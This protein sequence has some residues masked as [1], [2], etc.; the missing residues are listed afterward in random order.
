MKNRIINILNI[1]STNS[2]LIIKKILYKSL[3]V[4]GILILVLLMKMLDSRPTNRLLNSINN[5][6]NYDFNLVDDSKKI[7]NKGKDLLDQSPRVLEVFNVG[8]V[9]NY[10]SPIKG[11]L[12][13]EYDK[14]LNKGIDIKSDGDLEAKAIISGIVKEVVL[15]DTKGY[16]ITIESEDFE[17]IYGYLSKAYVS[18]GDRIESGEALGYLGTNKDGQKYLRFEIIKDGQYKNPKNYINIE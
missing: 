8:Q 14:D 7:F 18:V 1:L 17:H 9:H 2:S 15:T 5:S 4:I 6:I 10:K 11:T 12:H 16:Y 3:I 13:R